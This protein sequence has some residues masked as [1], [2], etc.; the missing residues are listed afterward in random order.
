M[1]VRSGRD[2]EAVP[3]LEGA[4]RV[5]GR[6]VSGLRR[7]EGE[8]EGRREGVSEKGEGERE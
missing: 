1:F 3:I 8:G 7:R 5:L 4:E 6:G 2:E